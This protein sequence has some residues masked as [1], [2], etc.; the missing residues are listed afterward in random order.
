[1]RPLLRWSRRPPRPSRVVVCS[2]TSNAWSTSMPRQRTVF[3]SPA[4]EG[5][6]V[7]LLRDA[8]RM[9]RGAAGFTRSIRTNCKLISISGDRARDRRCPNTKDRGRHPSSRLA[10]ASCRRPCADWRSA[11]TA[12]H[13]HTPSPWPEPGPR[14]PSRRRARRAHAR[15]SSARVTPRWPTTRARPGRTALASAACSRVDGH[16]CSRDVGSVGSVGEQQRS[17]NGASLMGRSVRSGFAK[18]PLLEGLQRRH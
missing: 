16:P 18:Q 15:A 6:L 17:S 12:C 10:G 2:A 8:L 9:L 13:R 4:S 11:T 1:M 5:T 7:L 14:R 3:P